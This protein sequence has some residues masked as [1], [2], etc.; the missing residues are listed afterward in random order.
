MFDEFMVSLLLY[1][2]D[3]PNSTTTDIAKSILN[4]KASDVRELRNLD[5]KIRQRFTALVEDKIV[6]RTGTKPAFYDVNR[7]YV[8]IGTDGQWS[9]VDKRLKPVT[10]KMGT[11]MS[12]KISDSSMLIRSLD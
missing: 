8:A 3:N 11:F 7:S 2:Y 6:V 1:L 4:G 10:K 9:F 5:N 12:I